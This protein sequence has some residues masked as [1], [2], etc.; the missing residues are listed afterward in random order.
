M[1]TI[2]TYF[3]YC[4]EI[5]KDHERTIRSGQV[6]HVKNVFKDP[7]RMLNFQSL[8]TK[9]ESC[10]NSKPGIMSLKIPYWTADIISDEILDLPEHD[11]YKNESEFYY[12]Y[13]NNTCMEMGIDSLV[14]N[15]CILPHTDPGPNRPQCNIIGLINLNQRDVSTA[16]WRFKGLL[17][18]DTDDFAD[19]YNEYV[20]D[21]NYDNYDEKSCCTTLHK[22]F[23]MTYGFNEAIFYD[24]KC[25]HSPVIDK[26]YT[27][28]NPRIMMRLSYVLDYDDE[29]CYDD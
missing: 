19:E 3:R 10:S 28:E 21:I 15:N 13:Y 2:D 27:R 1:E 24:S 20:N 9:W 14:S 26:Y 8:L 12:F 16:F 29:E 11:S 23:E 25:F 18:E 4:A 7:Y 6:T 17:M 5:S 22:A